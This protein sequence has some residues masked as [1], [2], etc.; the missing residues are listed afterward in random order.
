MIEESNGESMVQI[1][2]QAIFYL[3]LVK[4]TVPSHGPEAQTAITFS[5]IRFSIVIGLLSLANGKFK[6]IVPRI[7]PKRRNIDGHWPDT[8]KM[9]L[10]VSNIH[11]V[12]LLRQIS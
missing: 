3:F 5:D 6:V 7:G 1:G 8:C 12:C 9:T 4:E 11:N 2:I 10:F